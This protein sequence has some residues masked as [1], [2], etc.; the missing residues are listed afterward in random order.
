MTSVSYVQHRDVVG[1]ARIGPDRIV[2]EILNDL[3]AGALRDR[4]AGSS[5]YI[6]VR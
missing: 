2:V 6:P 1:D 4:I 5:G 3:H